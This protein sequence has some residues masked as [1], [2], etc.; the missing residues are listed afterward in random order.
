MLTRSIFLLLLRIFKRNQLFRARNIVNSLLIVYP[1]EI[2]PYGKH[3]F[4]I[5]KIPFLRYFTKEKSLHMQMTVI[6][7]YIIVWDMLNEITCLS[8]M[9]LDFTVLFYFQYFDASVVFC[10]LILYMTIKCEQ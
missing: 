8:F 1:V 3:V 2:A 10:S 7:P 5:S 4:L 9:S 6:F